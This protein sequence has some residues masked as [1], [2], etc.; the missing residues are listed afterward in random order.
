MLLQVHS[1]VSNH[2]VFLSNFYIFGVKLLIFS[3]CALTVFF[4]L[5]LCLEYGMSSEVSTLGDMYSFG[6]LVLEIL[7]GKR[8]TDKMFEDGLNLH[9]FVSISFP[10]NLLQIL[11]PRL[12]QT[13]EATTSDGDNW[14]LNQNVEKCIVSLFMIGLACSE[15]PPKERMNVVDLTKELSRIRKF[16]SAG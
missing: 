9:N 16:F 13:Y 4:F 8:P 11:D 7:T 2:S 15:D 6:I 12:I 14:N 1:E 5:F 3:Y 10:S